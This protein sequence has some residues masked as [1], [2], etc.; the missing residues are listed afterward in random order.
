[1]SFARSWMSVSAKRMRRLPPSSTE[2]TGAMFAAASASEARVCSAVSAF[3]VARTGETCS[4]GTSP[5]KF[6][7]V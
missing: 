7:S 1:M 2:A 4:A 5:K 6:G 3:S